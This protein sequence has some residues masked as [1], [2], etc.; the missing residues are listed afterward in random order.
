MELLAKVVALPDTNKGVAQQLFSGTSL[1]RASFWTIR[2]ET[3]LVLTVPIDNKVEDEMRQWNV[4]DVLYGVQVIM[5]FFGMIGFLIMVGS[6][7][8]VSD[9]SGR[10]KGAAASLISMDGIKPSITL[11]SNSS[12]LKAIKQMKSNR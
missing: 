6:N 5:R 8:R 2:D 1:A 3:T 7:K 11:Y 4:G 10:F 12:Y 9:Q